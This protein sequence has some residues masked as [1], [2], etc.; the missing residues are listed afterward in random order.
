MDE[1]HDDKHEHDCTKGTGGGGGTG[2]PPPAFTSTLP[3][4]PVK[5]K[6]DPATL[7]NVPLFNDGIP[8]S[9]YELLLLQAPVQIMQGNTTMIWGFD[10]KYLGPTLEANMAPM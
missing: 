1:D 10:G 9:Y 2:T 3:I 5:Q 7:P 8:T 4:P 6:V